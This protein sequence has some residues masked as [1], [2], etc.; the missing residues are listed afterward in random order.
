MWYALKDYVQE[1]WRNWSIVTG[2]TLPSHLENKDFHRWACCSHEVY[3]WFGSPDEDDA[4]EILPPVAPGESFVP[5][6]P[7][8]PVEPVSPWFYFPK[9][10]STA[11]DGTLVIPT[12]W[13]DR[14]GHR[15]GALT[16][17]PGHPDYELCRW[18]SANPDLF[19]EFTDENMAAVRA[20]FAIRSE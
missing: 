13:S 8:E 20:A 11:S 12:S 6:E 17:E 3:Y 18:L 9:S 4:E 16:I 2:I 1:F 14:N 19:P 15:S 10:S 7:D 5:V